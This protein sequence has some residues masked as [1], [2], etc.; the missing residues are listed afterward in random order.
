MT[1]RNAGSHADAP[2]GA[3][4]WLRLCGA[5]A[6]AAGLLVVASGGLGIT[7]RALVLVALPLLVAVVLGAWFAHRDAFPAASLA[8]V[9]FLAAVASWWSTALHLALAAAALAA[10]LRTPALWSAPI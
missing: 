8:L 9:L 7:H 2:L 1:G 6:S 10:T 4:P 5:G 3:G